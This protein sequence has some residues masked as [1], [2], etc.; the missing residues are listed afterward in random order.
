MRDEKIYQMQEAHV[1]RVFLLFRQYEFLNTRNMA[2]QQV[3][4]DRWSFLR[5]IWDPKWFWRLV[6]ARQI[7]LLAKCKEEER[8]AAEKPR[9]LAV[10][11][12]LG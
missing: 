1:R 7:E 9:I 5:A 3:L 10:G 8:K 2:I 6:D 11:N 4:S 12:G